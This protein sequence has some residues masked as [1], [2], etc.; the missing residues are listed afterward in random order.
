MKGKQ[1][2]FNRNDI[3]HYLSC[4]RRPDIVK[5]T[6]HKSGAQRLRHELILL[7]THHQSILLDTYYFEQTKQERQLQA[8]RTYLRAQTQSLLIHKGR[9]NRIPEHLLLHCLQQGR[10]TQFNDYLPNLLMEWRYASP[11]LYFSILAPSR[12]QC[13]HSH[14]RS[15]RQP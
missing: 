1:T 13:L 7:L 3:E 4:R 11:P 8:T 2:P 15:C 14:P 12:N 6:P 10:I 5:K 9:F